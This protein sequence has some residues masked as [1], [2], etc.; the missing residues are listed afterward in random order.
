MKTIFNGD[1]NSASTRIRG[2]IFTEN[3]TANVL[4]IQKD[5]TDRAIK[6]ARKSD[7]PVVYDLDDAVREKSGRRRKTMLELA[8]IVT[9][10]TEERAVELR[11][12][13]K[14]VHVVPDCIDYIRK[15]LSPKKKLDIN[16]TVTFGTKISVLAAKGWVSH[17]ICDRELMPGKFMPWHF[18][19]FP[20][21]LRRFDLCV[22]R[23]NKENS[24]KGNL[25]LITAMAMGVPCVVSDTPSLAKTMKDV[26]LHGCICDNKRMLELVCSGLEAMEGLSERLIQYAWDK[27]SPEISQKRFREVVEN[28]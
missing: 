1:M 2:Y 17:Y 6:A 15:P 25:R 28:L 24:P 19:T 20:S 13:A 7:I 10:D 8:D 26:G 21:I 5:A 3:V 4:Y 18:K 9:T 27:Y 16:D 14:V 22:L 11:K 12:Y 23:H